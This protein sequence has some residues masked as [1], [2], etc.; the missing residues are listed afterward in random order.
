MCEVLCVSV[1]AYKLCMFVR[2]FPICLC[3]CS[4]SVCT[5]VYYGRVCSE[6]TLVW[7][8]RT[9]LACGHVF[10]FMHTCG[11]EI[12]DSSRP[13]SFAI[14]A[15]STMNAAVKERFGGV[16]ACGCGR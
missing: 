6:Q 7:H 3:T 4:V 8:V 16:Q 1:C 12:G 5:L 10:L 13:L 15:A 14:S 2:L 11:L 9:L